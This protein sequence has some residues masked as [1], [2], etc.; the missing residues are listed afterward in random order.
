MAFSPEDLLGT[1]SG[2][3]SPEQLAS[4]QQ[5]AALLSKGGM[6]DKEITSPWQGV[7]MMA[8]ALSGGIMR[9]Q[10]GQMGQQNR[11]LDASGIM[12]AAQ[13]PG[14]MAGLD[15]PPSQQPP[16]AQA[17]LGHGAGGMDPQTARTFKL[18]SGN[19]PNAVTGSNQGWGQYGPAEQRPAI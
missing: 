17:S 4:V 13:P 19:N 11:N 5:Y 12:G 14:G 8:D 3:A 1:P 7:R 10:A 16:G 15:Q 18:E 2:Y 9:N 6:R